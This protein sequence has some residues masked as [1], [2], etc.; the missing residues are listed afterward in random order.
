MG[1]ELKMG[2]NED[3][4]WVKKGWRGERGTSYQDRVVANTKIEKTFCVLTVKHMV[5]KDDARKSLGRD[6]L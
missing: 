5:V 2:D 3:C 6:I 4:R 1:Q